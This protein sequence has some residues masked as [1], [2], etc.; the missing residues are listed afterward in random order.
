M[1]NGIGCN[2]KGYRTKPT[3]ITD[4]VNIFIIH[5]MIFSCERLGKTRKFIPNLIIDQEIRR[6]E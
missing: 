4:I 6:F 2:K 1:E 3:S 5:L